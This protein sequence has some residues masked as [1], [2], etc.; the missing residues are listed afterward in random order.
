MAPV[1]MPSIKARP[2]CEDVTDTVVPG[3]T[4]TSPPRPRRRI[5][6]SEPA[7]T[8]E[9]GITLLPA[10][11]TVPLE[12]FVSGTAAGCTPCVRA[13]TEGTVADCGVGRRRTTRR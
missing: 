7:V 6:V 11:N 2:L 1:L 8:E 4:R 13:G 3:Q 5:A 10:S 12:P 9:P